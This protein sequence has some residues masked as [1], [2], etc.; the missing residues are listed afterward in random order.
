MSRLSTRRISMRRHALALLTVAALGLPTTAEADRARSAAVVAGFGVVRGSSNGFS[1]HHVYPQLTPGITASAGTEYLEL[2]SPVVVYLFELTAGINE[3]INQHGL[4]DCRHYLHCW[5]DDGVHQFLNLHY[6]R[7][8][9]GEDEAFG[10]AVGGGLDGWILPVE[11]S[12]RPENMVAAYA[13]VT[14]RVLTDR[15][16]ASLV[17]MIGGGGGRGGS[18]LYTGLRASG[19]IRVKG[20]LA[21]YTRIHWVFLGVDEPEPTHGFVFELGLG[22]WLDR[23][24]LE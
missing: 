13:A 24:D 18:G 2:W 8:L 4:P 11:V 19:F 6:G 22:G 21:T 23:N 3:G 10:L 1:D 5:G 17:P 9:F 15:V 12:R 20:L 7:L 14:M 16:L